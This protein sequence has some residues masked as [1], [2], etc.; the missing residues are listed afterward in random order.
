MPDN[1]DNRT[2]PGVSG[3]AARLYMRPDPVD[4]V[5]EISYFERNII[6]Q[7]FH[8]SLFKKVTKRILLIISL[9]IF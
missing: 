1:T 6:A 7:T 9:I 5:L 2:P 3:R 8:K 4:F